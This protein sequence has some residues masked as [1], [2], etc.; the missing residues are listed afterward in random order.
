MTGH[1]FVWFVKPNVWLSNVY[2]IRNAV[3][4]DWCQS[5]LMLQPEDFEKGAMEE[6][7][8]EGKSS[9][10]EDDA[11]EASGKDQDVVFIQDIGFTVKV[12]APNVEAFD[13]QVWPH[14]SMVY[15]KH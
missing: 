13:I 5:I 7:E 3:I 14:N 2:C 12:V 4:Y 9:E 11:N 6:V 1:F 8:K 10:A 15:N